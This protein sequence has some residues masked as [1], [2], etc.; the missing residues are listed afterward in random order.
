[1]HTQHAGSNQQLAG[2]YHHSL[3]HAAFPWHN[4][5][6]MWCSCAAATCC[7]PP[8]RTNQLPYCS[9]PP[10]ALPHCL[11][12]YRAWLF[13]YAAAEPILH[14]AASRYQHLRSAL[15]PQSGPLCL[16]GSTLPATCCFRC[17][18]CCCCGGCNSSAP[19]APTWLVP[20]PP[21][22]CCCCGSTS[23]AASAPTN[24]SPEFPA[25][26]A[27]AAARPPLAHLHALLEGLGLVKRSL[28]DA[29]VH[30]KD[31]KVRVDRLSH[32]QEGSTTASRASSPHLPNGV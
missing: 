28:A 15:L 24:L 6:T 19:S 1:M 17:C 21:A 4:S 12:A 9:G 26:F 31:D 10:A 13:T 8:L 32:L 25:S 20:R 14:Q 16:F 27:T 23:S 30:H 2:H 3:P 22:S 11:P 29:T 5:H 18:Y 7:H